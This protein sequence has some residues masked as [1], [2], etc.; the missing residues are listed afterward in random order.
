MRAVAAVEIQVW[1]MG[2]V[3]ALRSMR[4]SHNCLRR[5]PYVRR[6]SQA[7]AR[8]LRAGDLTSR[9]AERALPG[10]SRKLSNQRR[11]LKS[12]RPLAWLHQQSSTSG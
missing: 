2:C 6:R 3:K 7:W 8:D 12:A 11:L 4:G 5:V 10:D 1:A 9:P